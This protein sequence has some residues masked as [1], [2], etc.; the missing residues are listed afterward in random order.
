MST[1]ERF[2]LFTEEYQEL[3]K[4][5]SMEI[6]AINRP[7]LQVFDMAPKEPIE[8]EVEKVEE[9]PKTEENTETSQETTSENKF[10]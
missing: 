9:T 2:K 6:R 4:K 3:C 1:E 7:T 5:H 8:A 10:E